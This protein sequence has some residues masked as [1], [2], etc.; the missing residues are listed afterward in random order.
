MQTTSVTNWMTEEI[1]IEWLREKK[2]FNV[3]FGTS[4]HPEVI[5]KSFYLLDFLYRHGELTENE[6][7]KMWHIA[8]KKHEAF[9]VSIMRS[10]IFMASRMAPKELQFLFTKLQ[11]MQL[12]EHDKFSLLLL[13]SIAK[14]LAPTQKEA[15]KKAT[16]GA[17]TNLNRVM[18]DEFDKTKKP[19]GRA[20]SFDGQKPSP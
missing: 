17:T 20:G 10:L 8:T 19:R 3:F 2:I 14:A 16:T 6:L 11:G 15:Q 9:K 13:K 12:R 1:L 5:K 18:L 7:N 4:L